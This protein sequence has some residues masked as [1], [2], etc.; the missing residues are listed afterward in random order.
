MMKMSLIRIP[1]SLALCLLNFCA[2]APRANAA[3]ILPGVIGDY[4]WKDLN[5]NGIQDT[6]EPGI[7]GI[8]VTLT[9]PT[10]FTVTATTD[11]TG[12]YLFTNLGTGN[13]TVAVATPSGLVPSPSLVGADR[14]VDSNGSVATVTI[15]S[16]QWVDH[17][18]DFGFCPTGS[19]GNFVW[20]DLNQNGFQDSGEPGIAGVTV[21]LMDAATPGNVLRTAVTG[22][23]GAYL[24]TGLAAGTYKVIVDTSSQA[25]AGFVP[26]FAQAFGSNAANDSD[27]S[28]LTV[29]LPTD[30][31]ADLDADFGFIATPP[32]TIGDF[33][34]FDR[35]HNGI[36]DAPGTP[37]FEPGIPGVTVQLINLDQ[38]GTPVATRETAADGYYLFAGLL[39]GRYRV[40]VDDSQLAL[41]NVGYLPTVT[42]PPDATAANDSNVNPTDVTL[43]LTPPA[44]PGGIS[45]TSSDTSVDFGYYRL[46]SLAGFVYVDANNDGAFQATEVPLQGV[47]VTLTGIDTHAADVNLT[48]TTDATGHYLFANLEPSDAAGYTIT[49]IQPDRYLDGKDTVGT[50]GGTTANDVFSAVVL[51]YGV[52]GE[53]NNFGELPP[54]SLAGTVF[55]DSNNNGVQDG[56]EPGLADVTVT[57]IGTD[58]LGAVNRPTTTDADGH[59]SFT[60]LRPGTYALAEAQPGGYL[61]GK[62]ALGTQGGTLGND[63]ISQ[64]T[65]PATGVNG[66]ENNFG[67]RLPSSLAGYVYLDANNDGDIAGEV[68]ITGVVV[69][70]TGADD[71]NPLVNLVTTTDVNG[72]YQFTSLRPGTY[73]ITESQP[74]G[75]LDGKDTIGTPGGTTANDVFSGILLNSGVNGVNNNFGELPESQPAPTVASLSGYVYVD[76]N[77]DGLKGANEAPISDVTVSVT[78]TDS[79]GNLVN[80]TTTTDTTGL[81][82]FLL[83][84]SNA[85]GYT[86][87]ETQP[88]GY[89]D[90]KDTIGTPG[91]TT[92]NDVFSNVVL[93]AGVNGANNN[94]GERLMASG[95]SLTKTVNKPKA[96]FGESVTYTYVVTNTGTMP[97]TNVVVVDDNATPTLGADDFTVDTLALLAPGA[98]QTFT[99][100][101]V[102]PAPIANDTF[103]GH[104][105]C[106]VIITEH[107]SDG[108][109][110]FTYLQ[111][112]DNREDYSF[113]SGWSGKRS[114]CTKSLFRVRDKTGAICKDVEAATCVGDGSKYVNSFSVLVDT[115]CVEKS[116]GSVNLPDVCHKSGWNKDWSKDWDSC[117]GDRDRKKCWDDDLSKSYDCAKHPVP[118]QGNMT[119]IAT[120]TAKAGASTVTAK[121]KATVCILPPPS[122]KVSI[123]KTADVTQA[124]VGVP[125]TYTYVVTNTGGVALTNLKVVDDNATPT[126]AT[127]D[128]Q[129]GTV[130]GPLAPGA[131]VTF[132]RTLVPPVPMFSDST[133]KNRCGTLITEKRSDGKT[134][135]TYCQAKDDRGNYSSWTGWKGERAYCHKAQ[136][137]VWSGDGKTCGEVAGTVGACDASDYVNSFSVL[138]NTS[139]VC[140]GD[141]SVKL[142][143]VCHRS[144]WDGDW[145]QDWDRN[146]GD[147]YRRAYWDDRCT[148]WD[149]DNHP[150]PCA[151]DVTN[152][153]TVTAT[154]GAVAVTAQDSET[155]KV[156]PPTPKVAITKTADKTLVAFGV[157]VTYTYVVTNTG[158]VALTNLKVMD[159]NATPT[160]S[161]DDVEIGTVAGPL[162]PGAAVTFTKTL[163]P[164]L[165]MGS[166]S[167]GTDRC[168]S[169]ITER[170]SDGTTKFTY[171]QAKDDRGSYSTSTGW[172]GERSYCRQAQFR[173]WNGNGKT[174]GDVA[175]TLEACDGADYVNGFSV[176]VSTASVC[177]SDGS[178]KLPDVCHKSGW[179]GD[180]HQ[181]WDR[182]CGDWYRRAYWDS[183]CTS[184]DRNTRPVPCSSD[185]T[186]IATVTA[187]A[188]AVALTAQD[189]ETVKVSSSGN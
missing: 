90:G 50:P 181:D 187:T 188:G 92:A 123:T 169:L 95:V 159:D 172:K 146:C 180:W 24:F 9:K 109:T 110:K 38:P 82:T 76:A 89:P 51:G 140:N 124:T 179:A 145:R 11:A 155:V 129:I 99:R 39:P 55:Q 125:V 72:W 28:P 174:Y 58:D 15:T 141:G 44:A 147:W 57:L 37:N 134:K 185:V 47:T 71:L 163:V 186:N 133:G 13:H 48:T 93:N 97:L 3:F 100:T 26:T 105:T 42:S 152:V 17:T 171:C 54:S 182:N 35:N 175:G 98:S 64:I 148:S 135:F 19:I 75:Y 68:A 85:A 45:T 116:D 164:T 84:P 143:D 4:V 41:K 18:N 161:T 14:T 137:R 60:G 126:I 103:G 130:V 67:E 21:Q 74:S 25:L 61:D 113:S 23:D 88:V 102:P 12:F 183:H 2:L 7:P 86:V 142:P 112:K 166:G 111:A 107:R 66:V 104:N 120:V 36:Q 29:V 106:G 62:D 177:K 121:G 119:N 160:I 122:P 22:N 52:A 31:T 70:L 79:N 165:Q 53:D 173:V 80:A 101:L 157:P 176:V 154:A 132:T 33:V 170:R 189:H 46:A 1:A 96:S 139:S 167:S 40:V 8:T 158:A 127:D 69:T 6:G 87:T 117:W 43:V 150:V 128:V 151:G 94:F 156:S 20:K 59:Y 56:T 178:I 73:T 114:Y 168:G 184:W 136:F 144:G 10:G 65:L 138:V 49:E 77:N 83:V 91:G 115:S 108:K 153:A 63:A 131:A 149:R 118:C 34:W 30:S 5:Q 27:A 78:G 162:A 32:G 81:Y 16:A